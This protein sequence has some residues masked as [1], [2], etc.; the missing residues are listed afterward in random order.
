MCYTC[1][2]K[3]RHERNHCKESVHFYSW[4]STSWPIAAKQQPKKKKFWLTFPKYWQRKSPGYWR[5]CCLWTMCTI[6]L[7]TQRCTRL[8]GDRCHRAGQQWRPSFRLH[9]QHDNSEEPRRKRLQAHRHT[10]QLG[11]TFAKEQKK[12]KRAANKNCLNWKKKSLMIKKNS[13]TLWLVQCDW[14]FLSWRKMNKISPQAVKLQV[15]ILDW[16]LFFRLVFTK[17]AGC[18]SM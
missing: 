5:Q 9:L 8:H 16:N 10:K 3:I 13:F 7:A 11:W 18:H 12:K 1:E 14:M 6:C 2:G 15:L 4:K 17:L